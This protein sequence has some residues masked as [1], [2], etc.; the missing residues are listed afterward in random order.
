MVW[1]PPYSI[2]R[3]EIL[4]ADIAFFNSLTK[5]QSVVITIEKSNQ[6][7]AVDLATYGWKSKLI[8]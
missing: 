2:L 5:A 4:I 1:E 6:F 7:E 8:K 3:N